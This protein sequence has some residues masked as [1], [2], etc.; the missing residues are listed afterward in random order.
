MSWAPLPWKAFLLGGPDRKKFLHGL[1]TNDVNNL[2]PG[3]ELPACVLTPKGMMQ[4]LLWI[5]D[6]PEGLLLLSPEEC[7]ANLEAALSKLV[8]LSESSLAKDARPLFWTDAGEGLPF[9]AYGADGRLV[10]ARPSGESADLEARR[11]E[12]ALPRWGVDVD[13]KTI[14]LEAGLER[15]ISYNKGCYMGQETI[16]RIHHLG[17][18]NRN[19]LRLRFEGQAPEAPA[20]VLKDGVEVGR[21]TSAAGRYGLAMVRY[22]AK[23]PFQIAGLSAA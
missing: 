13:D 2:Q 20:A 17:H 1:V 11:V 18:V 4:A 23:A 8:M 15:A 10:F 6:V 9:S 7:A 21:M 16:S 22:E 14:P 3:R 12:A 19:L 5:Y